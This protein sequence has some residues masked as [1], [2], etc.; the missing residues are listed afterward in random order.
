[1]D[2]IKH[3]LGMAKV[4]SREEEVTEN[5]Q[6]WLVTKSLTPQQ[7]QYLSLLKNRGIVGGK[8]E[9]DDL[10]KPPLSILNA[11]G[12]GIELFGET[13]LKEVIRDLNESVFVGRSA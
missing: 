12:L 1:M 13:G 5:F 8:L 10:F 4:K 9:L 11:A 7:A 2:F 3:A 6:A